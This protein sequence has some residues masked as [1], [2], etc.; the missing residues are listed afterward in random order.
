MMPGPRIQPDSRPRL[1]PKVRLRFDRHAQR[2]MLVYPDK[3]MV[4]NPSAAAIA[5]LCT[6]EH[7]FDAIVERLCTAAAGAPR[8]Q[9]ERDARAFLEALSERALLRIEE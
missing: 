9:V 7:T 2:H 5:E 1:A 3:G 6:G 8:E 4:L